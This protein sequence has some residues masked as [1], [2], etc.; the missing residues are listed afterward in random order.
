[1]SGQIDGAP[2][3]FLIDSGAAVSVVHIKALPKNYQSSLTNDSP[4][5]V[6]ANGLALDVIGQAIM[7]IT[8][9][10][11][12][13]KHSFSVVSDL[14]VDCI[15]GADFLMQNQAV[16]DCN[17]MNLKLGEENIPMESGCKANSC[18][19]VGCIIAHQNTQISGRTVQL[20]MGVAQFPG[21]Q[22][23]CHSQYVLVEPVNISNKH[24]L[25][26]CSISKVDNGHVVL[27]VMNTSPKPVTIY[28]G[29][30]LATVHQQH[31]VL[32][33]TEQE[34]LQYQ[35]QPNAVSLDKVSVGRSLTSS[36]R[37]E[38]DSLLQDF[39]DIFSSPQRPYG[40]TE[41]VKHQIDTRGPPIRQPFR[42]VPYSLRDTLQKEVDSMLNNR[43]IRP[44][45][46]PWSSPVVLVRKGDG[47][48]RFCVDFRKVNDVTR[49]DAYPL[50]RI[51]AT[52]EALRG[53]VYFT[54]LDLASGYWQVE[55]G[56]EAKEKT[57]FS[58]VN[59]HY[60]F[61][62]MPFGLT[63]APATFQRLMECI[64]SGLNNSECLIYLDDV[65][66]FSTSFQE[67]MERL[68]RV[69]TK[70]KD[71]GLLLKL[72]KCKFAQDEVPYLGFI[73][74]ARGVQPNPEKIKAVLNYPVP[75]NFKALR[76][77]LGMSNY[78]RRFIQGYSQIVEPLHKLTR[79]SSKQFQWT[80]ECQ[81]SFDK[82]KLLLTTPPIL[83]YP[84]F[85]K[86]FIVS[87]DASGVAIG[88]TLY[89]RVKK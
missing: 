21:T 74:S 43:V 62:V 47:S 53:S 8:V 3:T 54:T 33:V 57:A 19:T 60:E 89:R 48:R 79:K 7:P 71:A 25:V 30:R 32:V 58:T 38:L 88:A 82:L 15:L 13:V 75:D 27:Q 80:S 64:L 29:S 61:N 77:F 18:P 72:S 83:A 10:N 50:P 9:G 66:V 28:R 84:S 35:R 36:Q 87:T 34:H 81:N 73:V 63:N 4:R 37:Q 23:V 42:R 55:L 11:V 46:S 44:S 5:I 22:E 45:T 52:V 67:H 20:M 59:G 6:G 26:A 17:D 41:V 2:T 39:S 76:Q 70:L 31:S 49:R 24:L 1:M 78:Y 85:E 40:K 56:E 68:H 69:L 86:Q 51:D 14:T 12:E 65:I 16:I